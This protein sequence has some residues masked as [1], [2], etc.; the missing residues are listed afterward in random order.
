MMGGLQENLS[1]EQK[2]LNLLKEL[3]HIDEVDLEGRFLDRL[4]PV[5]AF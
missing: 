2:L 4:H 3:R 5:V 1:S